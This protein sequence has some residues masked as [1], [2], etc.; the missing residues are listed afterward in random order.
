MR[1]DDL[2]ATFDKITPSE[3]LIQATLLK[4][5]EQKKKE[6]KN[7]ISFFRSFNYRYVGA[8]C[9]LALVVFVG[10][11]ITGL[12]G[13]G[14][15]KPTGNL[16]SRTGESTYADDNA[17]VGIVSYTLDDIDNEN[18]FDV[19][20]ILSACVL[21]KPTEEESEQGIVLC[22]ELKIDVES[23]SDDSPEGIIGKT[24]DAKI[25]FCDNDKA[26][27]LV[28]LVSQKV[29]FSIVPEKEAYRVLDF[30]IEK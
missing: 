1:K 19:S 6:E 11:A 20:G 5:E 15:T 16:Y 27:A 26:E 4:I 7:A 17:G 8:F 30:T 23:R 14:S 12:N 21:S 3:E 9:A 10:F 13:A 29:S 18:A 2:K 25:C 28:E 22:G 24:I